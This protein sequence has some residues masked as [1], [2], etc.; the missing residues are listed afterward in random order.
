VVSGDFYWINKTPSGKIVVVAADCTGHGVPGAFMSMIGNSLL[1]EIIL[2]NGIDDADEILNRLK[3]GIIK[4]L[5]QEEEGAQS[6]DGMD[7]ALTV[8]DPSNNT[9]EYAGANNSL[10]LI[11]PLANGQVERIGLAPQVAVKKEGEPDPLVTPNLV[12]ETHGLFEIKPDKQPIGYHLAKIEPFTKHLIQ[13]QEGDALYLFT[14]G[15]ADQ[16]GGPKGK[17]FKYKPFKNLLLS[18]YDQHMQKQEKVLNDTLVSWMGDIEQV[19][20]ICVVAFKI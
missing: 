15:Y 11:R 8:L 6:K 20:D 18:L 13:L 9:L 2:E 16:F 4:A 10:Y 14:D 17:K 19:D 12:S 3:E 5:R 1:N 7:L